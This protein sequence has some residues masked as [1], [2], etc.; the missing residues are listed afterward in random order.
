M[1][2]ENIVAC[3]ACEAPIDA[4]ETICETGRCPA[5]RAP[6]D[7]LFAEANDE[8]YDPTPDDVAKHYEVD[9]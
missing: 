3:P 6:L 8:H 7:Q 9:A 1:T 2:G 5:C 4:V